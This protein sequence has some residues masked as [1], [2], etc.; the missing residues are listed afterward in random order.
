MKT[1]SFYRADT[2]A[3][4]GQSYAGPEAHLEANTPTGC[5]AFE[6]ALDHLAE[7]VDLATG[8]R[9][10]WQPDPPPDDE[11][12]S[13]RWDA[14]TRRYVD[15]PTLAARKRDAAAPVLAR[16][17][18]LD[19]AAAR[20]MGEIALALATAAPV[21]EAARDALGQIEDQKQVLR[22]QLAAIDAANDAQELT[23]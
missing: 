16:L 5:A 1:W 6:G 19:L 22:Q 11:F 17:A 23:P 10:P 9:V 8:E 18:A 14:A 3:P 13:W 4:T 12:R 21:P 2:G 7:R 20:P 15:Q